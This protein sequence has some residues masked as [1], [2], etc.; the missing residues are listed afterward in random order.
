MTLLTLLTLLGNTPPSNGLDP[1]V[2]GTII[3]SVIVALLGTGV[4]SKKAGKAEGKAEAMQIGPQP[5]IVELKETFVTRR[6]HDRLEALVAVNAS[7][8][9]GLF[10]KTMK[11]VK[12]LNVATSAAISKQGERLSQEIEKVAKGAYEGRQ[13]LHNTVN[14]QGEK[15]A[16]LQVGANVASELRQVSETIVEAI[17]G[18]K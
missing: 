12:D 10:E 8:M 9:E 7:K 17:N 3:G 6:E 5:F 11:E 4:L 13:R 2:V 1:A 15:I 16:A 14:A 18:K